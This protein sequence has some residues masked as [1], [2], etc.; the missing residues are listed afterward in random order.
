MEPNAPSGPPGGVSAGWY[1]DPSGRFSQRYFDGG[2]WTDQVVGANGMT[3]TD[4]VPG[5][6]A[7]PETQ[8][9]D[10]SPASAAAVA[11]RSEGRRLSWYGVGVAALG[12]VV[13]GLSVTALSWADSATFSDVR[14]LTDR[15]ESTTYDD[16]KIA[17]HYGAWGWILLLLLVIAGVALVAAAVNRGDGTGLRVLV[18]CAAGAGVV[19]HAAYVAKVFEGPGPSPGAGAWAGSIGY[20]ITIIG[21][22][23]AT[24]RLRRRA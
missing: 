5:A 20:L 8:A 24:P 13:T 23:I 14:K 12:V 15:W 17:Y 3:T 6:A 19:W 11:P 7:G 22:A 9:P 10:A 16:A 4:A 21:L 2:G 1:P 18:A